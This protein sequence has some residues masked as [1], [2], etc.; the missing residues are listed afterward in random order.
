M[1]VGATGPYAASPMPTRQRVSSM[2]ANVGASP[3]PPLARLQMMT[4]TATRSHRR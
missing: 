3:L 2:T 4:P 1:I